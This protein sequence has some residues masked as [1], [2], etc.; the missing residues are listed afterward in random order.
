MSRRFRLSDTGIPGLR[1]V[2][3]LR[4]EDERGYL[5][6]LFC[7]E[8]LREAGWEGPI[9]QINRTLTAVSGTVRGMH[10]QHPP[11]AETKLVLCLRGKVFDVAVDLRADSPTRLH[12][13]AE[14]LTPT[15]GRALLIPQ[16]FAHGFQTL[17]ADVELLYLHSAAYAA[18]AEGG[19]HPADPAI[20]IRWP[21]PISRLS[22]RD[23][24]HPPLRVEFQGITI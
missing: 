21:L 8:E 22:E 19:I 10:Y 20:S 1:I 15:N 2:E 13:H 6:R 24:R 3:R 9:A 11:F 5:E 17:S 16:G 23:E 12:W 14:V 7:A 18:D 4:R